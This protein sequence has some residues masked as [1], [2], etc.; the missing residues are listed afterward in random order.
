VEDPD[1][2]ANK[3]SNRKK[4]FH[5]SMKKICLLFSGIPGCGKDSLAVAMGTAAGLSTSVWTRDL[6]S[7]QPS[8]IVIISQD[9]LGKRDPCLAAFR[10]ALQHP[11]IEYVMLTRNNFAPKDRE[12]W[13]QAAYSYTE[14]VF[15]LC[16][17]EL[18]STED[19]R[20]Q[21]VL[22]LRSVDHVLNRK[23]HPTGLD[24]SKNAT[25]AAFVDASFFASHV[26]PSADECSNVL[27]YSV[28]QRPFSAEQESALTSYSEHLSALQRTLKKIIPFRE[29]A[30]YVPD[31][32][33]CHTYR[34]LPRD[35]TQVPDDAVS[36][37]VILRKEVFPLIPKFPGAVWDRPLSAI[38][39]DVWNQLQQLL[40]GSH[41]DVGNHQAGSASASE[42]HSPAMVDSEAHT[43]LESI[44]QTYENR[45]L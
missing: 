27:K 20:L 45:E 14:D 15:I 21:T 18:H 2:C 19:I 44:E 28:L 29:A 37:L 36:A 34:R 26:L 12:V 40:S 41:S 3:Q 30:K 42:S 13:I 35:A 11:E 38:A 31:K 23:D 25:D 24:G 7:Q 6:S 9:A 4:K 10:S 33:Q 1:S 8:R 5:I 16:P 43:R 39:Q 22:F 32:H 17:E